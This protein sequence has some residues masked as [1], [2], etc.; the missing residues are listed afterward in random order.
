M[1]Q[2][3]CE[4][5]ERACL[6]EKSVSSPEE[7][8]GGGRR[9]RCDLAVRTAPRKLGRQEFLDRDRL[10]EVDVLALVDDAEV[11]R[12]QDASDT[13]LVDHSADGDGLL[14]CLSHDAV[15]IER[16]IHPQSG[17]WPLAVPVPLRAI[18]GTVWPSRMPLE[19]VGRLDYTRS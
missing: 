17:R 3:P 18:I 15:C 10:V 7:C 5:P 1:G 6:L 8:L 14:I 11:P 19:E 4:I 16:M 9:Q 13:E 2:G 12:A